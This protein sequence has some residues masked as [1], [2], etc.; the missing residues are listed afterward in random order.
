M[1]SDQHIEIAHNPDADDVIPPD[2]AMA[3]ASPRSSSNS[4]LVLFS[5]FETSIE[6]A[7]QKTLRRGRKL[8]ALLL[9][10]V[11]TCERP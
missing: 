3:D 1:H 9:C 5:D 8:K 10:I 4:G 2:A 6:R 7:I 11:R